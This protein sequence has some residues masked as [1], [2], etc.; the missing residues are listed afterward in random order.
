MHTVFK[1]ARQLCLFRRLQG[2]QS[3]QCNLL[4]H[5]SC[6]GISANDLLNFIMI[7]ASSRVGPLFIMY[8]KRE[9]GMFT[10]SAV[11]CSYFR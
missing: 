1:F 8:F 10:L 2:A 7:I 11:R 3:I 5:F 9:P 6:C 4:T